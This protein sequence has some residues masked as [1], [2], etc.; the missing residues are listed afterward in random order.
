[1]S[2]KPLIQLI[3]QS[4]IEQGSFLDLLRALNGEEADQLNE[5]D[6]IVHFEQAI[7]IL[8]QMTQLQ[9]QKTVAESI[10]NHLRTGIILLD[11][12]ATIVFANQP[13]Q[14][15]M[16]QEQSLLNRKGCLHIADTDID[17]RI[18]QA[19]AAW[20]HGQPHD[21][22]TL[23]L[24]KDDAAKQV[25]VLSRT[26]EVSG[27]L[28]M[29]IPASAIAALFVSYSGEISDSGN[30]RL[31]RL[32]GLTRVEAD[33]TCRLA[34]G[35]TI[36]DI[37]AI[38]QS[39]PQTI[40]TYLKSIY[41]KTGAKRQSDL[42]A[43]VLKAPLQVT[44]ASQ[45]HYL[46]GID[47]FVESSNRRI[48]Y[49]VSGP[50]DGL[51]VVICPPSLSCRLCAPLDPE[52][53]HTLGIRL[54]VLD[55]AAVGLTDGPRYQSMLDFNNDLL[56]VLAEENIEQAH[57]VGVAAGGAYALAAAYAHPEKVHQVLL[58]E[59]FA[60][61]I[62]E[63]KIAGAPGYFRWIPR[64][65]RRFPTVAEKMLG[66]MLQEFSRDWSQTLNHVGQLFNTSD[67]EQLLGKD[68][69]EYTLAQGA[70]SS[71][72]GVKGF[73]RCVMLVHGE[74]PF[75]LSQVSRPCHVVYGNA[76]PVAEAYAQALLENL[77]DATAHL[78]SGDAFARMMYRDF[79]DILQD[80]GWV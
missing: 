16:Q 53:L 80:I 31:I 12:D 59:S 35:Q 44:D 37:A 32:Y 3:Y 17:K 50:A 54:I 39:K 49:R 78:R 9:H 1:M 28:T 70:E 55:R 20:Q 52:P 47:K 75:A 27:L 21:S 40:R 11:A 64:V 29:H 58:L 10:F 65:M 57:I 68:M 18:K 23:L 34:S 2:S 77:P 45:Q 72:N 36:D 33:V 8:E 76:D 61:G 26:S 7:Q 56:A 41:A 38:R 22:E 6:L 79:F 25:A 5:A 69:R 13:A 43:L 60:P 19:L 63:H 66:I 62:T 48:A 30:Q 24:N 14:Q 74:W 73:L 67:A 4:A 42:I 51:P 15:L 71:R 46:P